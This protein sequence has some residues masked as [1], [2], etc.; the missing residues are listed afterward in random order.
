MGQSIRLLKQAT[1]AAPPTSRRRLS[2][3]WPALLG[4]LLA[5][6]AGAGEVEF[7]FTSSHD[8]SRQLAT[9]YVP[10]GRE[11]KKSPLLVIAHYWQGNRHTARGHRYYP[12]CDER[13]WLLVCPELHGARTSGK[14]SLA[15]VPAQHDIIDAIRYMQA[16]YKIDASRIYVAGRSMGG[17]L[18][19]MAA[20]KYPDV[21]AAAVAGQGISDLPRWLGERPDFK[22]SIEAECGPYDAAKRFEYDRRSA[23]NYA[24]NL[25]YVPLVL[26]HGTNDRT[27]PPEQSERLFNAMRQHNRL[28]APVN[29]LEGAP[30]N[31][32]NFDAAWVCDRLQYFVNSSG[33]AVPKTRF[34][35]RLQLVTDESKA[36]FWL[37]I[38]Q[39]RKGAFSK[40]TA[41]LEDGAL[42]ATG[43]NVAAL[44]IDLDLIPAAS[45]CARYSVKTDGPMKL[46][47]TREGRQ[48]AEIAVAQEAVGALD[49]P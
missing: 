49:L 30:H 18:A 34:Y 27:V 12:Q 13:G 14:T 29:W 23:V 38:E 24:A 41:S 21:F 37:G 28:Q 4:T 8:A 42:V 48:L 43:E 11:A 7:E 45:R 17:M 20:A 39:R 31:P 10:E 36:Y 19:M 40:V 32:I 6:V 25:Q 46:R 15:A 47:F 35:P 44:S 22:A 33:S 3:L 26:W 16:K 1:I 5:A 9:A 2:R